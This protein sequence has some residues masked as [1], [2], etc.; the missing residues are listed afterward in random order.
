MIKRSL[1][2]LVLAV[3]TLTVFGAGPARAGG[4]EFSLPQLPDD[5][6][7]QAVYEYVTDLQVDDQE[8][9]VQASVAQADAYQLRTQLWQLATD[10]TAARQATSIALLQRDAALDQV[11]RLA[12]QVKAQR[13]TIM[14]LRKRLHAVI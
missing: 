7:S 14:H 6:V 10:I 8:A 9:R 12:L 13:V 3:V 2:A 5:C 11:D 4:C 1:A